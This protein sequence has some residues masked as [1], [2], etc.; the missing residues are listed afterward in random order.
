MLVTNIKCMGRKERTREALLQAA[1]ELFS[2]QG[3]D[4]TTTAAIARRAGV[5]EMTLFRHF[6]TKDALLVDDPYDPLIGEAITARPADERPL[7]AA[8]RGVRDA[9]GAIPE[10]ATDEVRERLQVVAATPSLTG[11]L[12]RSS[13]ETEEAIADALCRRGASTSEARVVAAAVVA[14]LNAALLDWSRG[15][16]PHLGNAVMTALRALGERP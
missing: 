1:L 9:W 10:P 3:Y 6:A 15:T 4:A 5:S 13:R 7:T 12:A 8:V 16:D 2:E 11:A 14:G